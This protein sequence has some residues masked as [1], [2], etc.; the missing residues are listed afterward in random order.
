MHKAFYMA[1]SIIA[2]ALSARPA[3]AIQPFIFFNSHTG[4]CLQPANG[5]TAAGTAIVQEPCNVATGPQEW[6]Y[7]NVGGGSFHFEHAASGLCLDARG[8]ATNHTPVQLWTCDGITNENWEP[9]SGPKGESVGPVI[10]RVSGTK[11][12]CLDIPG[13]QKTTGLAMQ[14]YQCNGTVSQV[15]E[16]RPDN[17]V[18][19]PNVLKLSEAVATNKIALYGLTSKVVYAKKCISPGEVIEEIPGA[20]SHQQPNSQIELTVDNGTNCSKK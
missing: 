2:I 3:A 15:W 5:S 13:G 16:L 19:V 11:T 6:I 14:I 17:A 10:S 20:G 8:S 1:A 4:M 18:L 7:V 12:H 9:L